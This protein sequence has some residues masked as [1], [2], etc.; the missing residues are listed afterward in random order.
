MADSEHLILQ[1]SISAK[2]GLLLVA[3]DWFQF[4]TGGALKYLNMCQ[5]PNSNDQLPLSRCQTD[6][7]HG[8][9]I[10]CQ[11]VGFNTVREDHAIFRHLRFQFERSGGCDGAEYQADTGSP[12][13]KRFT[14][15]KLQALFMPG[16]TLL[17]RMGLTAGN[18]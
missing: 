6:R 18:A 14:N 10:E 4:E 11:I 3:S 17:K 12:A 15:G 9:G 5:I 1:K 2:A 16:K 13:R 7:H 8:T